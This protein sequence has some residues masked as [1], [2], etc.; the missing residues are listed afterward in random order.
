MVGVSTVLM[1]KSAFGRLHPGK[2]ASTFSWRG[3]LRKANS[4]GEPDGPANR[5]QPI[6]SEIIQ[7]SVAAGSD[8]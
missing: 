3:R 4:I 7:T 8:R 2:E 5:S 1:G 6:R